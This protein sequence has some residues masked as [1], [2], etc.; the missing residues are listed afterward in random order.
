MY[1][2]IDGDREYIDIVLLREGI[3]LGYVSLKP[4]ET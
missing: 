2:Y 1:I 3:S 4:L